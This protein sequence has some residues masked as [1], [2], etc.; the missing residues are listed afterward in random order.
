MSLIYNWGA[1]SLS[2]HK[3][4]TSNI[5]QDT[6]CF[7]FKHVTMCLK[8]SVAGIALNNRGN[9]QVV[10]CRAGNPLAFFHPVIYETIMDI[11]GVK[12]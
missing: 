12:C 7:N 2:R 6:I 11:T 1:K 5:F 8:R 10:T 9:Q 4:I 3:K